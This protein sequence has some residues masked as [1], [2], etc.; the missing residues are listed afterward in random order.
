MSAVSGTAV[1]HD[2]AF[3]HT[4]AVH[5][6]TFGQLIQELAPGLHVHHVVDEA[7]LT[8][9]QRIGADD[10]G[11]VARVHASMQ[12]AATSGASIVICTCS[13][14]GGAAERT[15]SYGKFN[16]ARIDRAMADRAVQ[17]GPR[18]LLV[19]ALASTLEPSSLLINESAAAQAQAV[20]ISHLLVEGAW[21]HFQNGERDA[22]LQLITDAITKAIS[23]N[24]AEIDVVV[25]AQASMAAVADDLNNRGL[26]KEILASPRLGVAHALAYIRKRDA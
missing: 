19:A 2:L 5:I 21:A 13:T 25:L 9:A 17:L 26:G 16:V 24:A 8:D 10:P 6:P 18:I 1:H 20:Q 15:P 11:I 23:T 14:I 22:Y 4:S 12:H 7:L 3:L